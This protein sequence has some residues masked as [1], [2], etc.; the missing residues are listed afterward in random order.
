MRTPILLPVLVAA[1][2]TAPSAAAKEVIA[3]EVCGAAGCVDRTAAAGPDLPG[4]LESGLSDGGPAAKAPFVNL[5]AGIGERRRGKVFGHVTIAFVP[6]LGLLRAADGQWTRPSPARAARLRTLAHGVRRYRASR[7]SWGA[8]PA[9]V[10]RAPEVDE[11]AKAAAATVTGRASGGA[12]PAV[13]GATAAGA[14]LL[15]LGGASVARR[16]RSAI[17]DGPGTG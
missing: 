3:L 13:V 8:D 9:P 15:L 7:L 4:L 2:A 16:R 10:S 14:S 5:R 6:S 12:S 1:L 11:P 17:R